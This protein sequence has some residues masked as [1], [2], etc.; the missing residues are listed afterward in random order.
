MKM[1]PKV[2]IYLALS[3]LTLIFIILL[4]LNL[5]ILNFKKSYQLQVISDMD[6]QNK[7]SN[8]NLYRF[9]PLISDAFPLANSYPT[10]PLIYR[11]EPQDYSIPEKIFTNPLPKTNFVVSRGKTLFRRFCIPCHNEDGKGKGPIVTK[12]ELKADEEGFPP[13]KDLTSEST[14]K[15]TDG[16]LFHILSAGQN[17]MFSFH[18][19]LTI[20]DKWALIHYIRELQYGK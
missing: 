20:F 6:N 9:A 7:L 4:C 11:F 14:R 1:V 3:L 10:K 2:T 19:K 12:V 17:L 8:D 5:G 16:R 13:P 15:M 18:D